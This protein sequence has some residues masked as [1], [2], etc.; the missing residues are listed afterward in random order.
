MQ[1]EDLKV[2]LLGRWLRQLYC[3]GQF[4]GVPAVI[5]NNG[6]VSRQRNPSGTRRSQIKTL[7]PL[8]LSIGA[9]LCLRVMVAR[10]R[11]KNRM[12][13]AVQHGIDISQF[14]NA[15]LFAVEKISAAKD[16]IHLILIG[17]CNQPRKCIQQF[18]STSVSKLLA[19]SRSRK[20]FSQMQITDMQESHAPPPCKINKYIG[21]YMTIIP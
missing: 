15:Q 5:G 4:L 19:I 9:V 10:N 14:F 20:S 17:K 6:T 13:Q 3:L 12:G 21:F 16:K 8:Y 2:S 18:L 11:N 7:A 1:H